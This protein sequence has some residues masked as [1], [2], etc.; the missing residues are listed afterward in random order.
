ML[1]DAVAATRHAK[2]D[3]L[4]FSHLRWDFVYQRV[5]HLLSRAAARYRVTFWEEPVYTEEAAHRLV[6]RMSPEGVLVVQP[7]V[8]WGADPVAGQ[9]DMLDDLIRERG[10]R[11]QVL[12]YYTPMAL[13]FSRHLPGRPIVY[14]CMDELS[15]FAGADATLPQWERELMQ[16]ATLVFT[17]GLSLLEA[18]RAQH[19]AVY[20]FP[21]G[22][23]VAHFAPARG[24]LAEPADQAAIGCFGVLDERLD[25][26]LL[27]QAAAL[28]PD[29]Q[30]VL[31]GPLAKLDEEELPHAANLHYLGP[32]HYDALPGYIAHWDVAMMPFAL[33]EATRF[34]S[35]T[36]TPEYLAAGRAVVST[37]IAD[38]ARS[39]G[40]TGYVAI[41]GDAASFMAAADAA[42]ALAP[43]WQADADARLAEMSWDRIWQRMSA[44]IEAERG[45][46]SEPRRVVARGQTATME[47]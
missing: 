21:S 31:I 47:R 7:H 38:V 15:A 6:T 30:F 27:A 2:A 32:K 9:R 22:V 10:I 43:G 1:D 8:P 23:D 19:D 37:P 46:P 26:G 33:N 36:K 45:R 5:Q 11:D 13:A 24:T 42:K 4:C 17:G 40:T 18:K 44:L 28:R 35:P 20:G 29:W 41:A 12:W 16:R 34:I 39:W 3:L 14:D 25:R